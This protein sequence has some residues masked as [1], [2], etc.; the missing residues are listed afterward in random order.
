[1][2]AMTAW[3]SPHPRRP[4]APRRGHRQTTRGGAWQAAPPEGGGR[5]PPRRPQSAGT[6]ATAA[7][8]GEAAAAHSHGGARHLGRGC[9]QRCPQRPRDRRRSPALSTPATSRLAIRRAATPPAAAEATASAAPTTETVGADAR[10]VATLRHLAA[11]VPAATAVAASVADVGQG[12]ADA[13][14]T[15]RGV[16]RPTGEPR[17]AGE[18]PAPTPL[19]P[20]DRGGAPAA[21]PTSDPGWGTPW[22]A[23]A[24]AGSHHFAGG[25][26]GCG[27]PGR[28][29]GPDPRRGGGRPNLSRG[30]NGGGSAVRTLRHGRGRPHPSR[31]GG[32]PGPSGGQGSRGAPPSL[33]KPSCPACGRAVHLTAVAATA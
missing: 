18:P 11:V 33:G 19:A 23:P 27:G 1:M 4:R 10:G 2:A 12:E 14:A 3:G 26:E 32:H 6:P 15:A 9:R 8:A 13:T 5:E 16:Q 22:R 29:R 25:G 21:L 30:G 7:V 17:P 20:A 28:A 24:A 31:G